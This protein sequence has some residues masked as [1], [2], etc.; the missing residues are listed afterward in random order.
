MFPSEIII[1]KFFTL[2]YGL[3]S[4]DLVLKAA[5][6]LDRDGVINEAIIHDGKP[7]A[8]VHLDELRLIE[9]VPSVLQQF[10]D[11]GFINV[12]VTNQPDISTGKQN[13]SDLNVIH[14]NLLSKLNLATI[15]VCPHVN[16]HQCSCRKP[17]PGLLLQAAEE[18]EI[19]LSQSFM[20][21]DRWSDIAAGQAAGCKLNFFIDYG[22]AENQPVEPYISVKSL[23]DAADKIFETI[24]L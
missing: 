3:W 18:L 5:I 4:T 19:D 6:F 12:V 13:W 21:G 22:Y 9:G 20:I 14:S 8:P 23:S 1:E 24:K 16:F 15:K 7:Y 17:K 2:F 10:Y 11:A